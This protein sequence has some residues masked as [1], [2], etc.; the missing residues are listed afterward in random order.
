MSSFA[1]RLLTATVLLPLVILAIHTHRLLLFGILALVAVGGA[2]LLAFTFDM[3]LDGIFIAAALG[4]IVYGLII[5]GALK[6]G[7][8]R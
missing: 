2:L 6:L 3:G 8:W 5:A 4:M 7:A 1:K